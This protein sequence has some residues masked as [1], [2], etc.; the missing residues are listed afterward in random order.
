MNNL[1][2]EIVS[3]ILSNVSIMDYLN[4]ILTC[5]R[6]Y[7]IMTDAHF[8]SKYK[9]SFNKLNCFWN[10]CT[11][12]QKVLLSIATKDFDCFKYLINKGNVCLIRCIPRQQEHISIHLKMFEYLEDVLISRYDIFHKC[13]I[14]SLHFG[15]KTEIENFYFVCTGIQEPRKDMIYKYKKHRQYRLVC[16]QIK[17]LK[18]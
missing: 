6:F 16:E 9:W 3:I 1:P 8:K 11:D 17:N 15:Q 5:K 7:E 10:M 14:N 2:P 12:Y 4:V 13:N 18:K